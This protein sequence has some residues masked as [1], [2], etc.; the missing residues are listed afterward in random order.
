[1]IPGKCDQGEVPVRDMGTGHQIACHLDE[2]TLNAM[3]PVITVED[4]AAAG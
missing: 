1:V 3:E 2:A 4:A